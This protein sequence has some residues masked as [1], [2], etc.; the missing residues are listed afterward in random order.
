MELILDGKIFQSI[1]LHNGNTKGLH[2]GNHFFF[3]Q[4][5]A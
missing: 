2:L 1:Q 3:F 5:T 4:S